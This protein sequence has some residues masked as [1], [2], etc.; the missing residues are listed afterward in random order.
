MEVCMRRGIAGGFS[1]AE[2]NLL[3]VYVCVYEREETSLYVRVI[4]ACKTLKPQSLQTAGATHT[5][6]V[7][8]CSRRDRF[9]A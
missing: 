8:S 7:V 6:N 4:A 1:S 9:T 5:G 3:C 2:M